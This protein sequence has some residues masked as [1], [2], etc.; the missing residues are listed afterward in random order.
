MLLV[1]TMVWETPHL[2]F[3]VSSRVWPW[4]TVRFLGSVMRFGA[5]L[6]VTAQT[7]SASGKRTERS[8]RESAGRCLL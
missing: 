3:G 2:T 6:T 4:V 1:Q 7:P 5:D 8:A